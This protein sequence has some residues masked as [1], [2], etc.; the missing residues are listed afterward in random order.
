MT[1][2]WLTPEDIEQIEKDRS[3]MCNEAEKT[4]KDPED[5]RNHN[6]CNHLS[7]NASKMEKTDT[8]F[9][10]GDP[11]EDIAAKFNGSNFTK[12]GQVHIEFDLRLNWSDSWKFRI[13]WTVEQVK[14]CLRQVLERFWPTKKL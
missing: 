8:N 9:A 12:Y 3:W 14:E 1:E 10:R 7:F 11:L 2:E 13:T 6:A 4:Q 5:I